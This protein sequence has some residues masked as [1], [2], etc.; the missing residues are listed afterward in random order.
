M[1]AVIH[2]SEFACVT[3]EP[4][5]IRVRRKPS[6]L[7][8]D[9]SGRIMIDALVDQFRMLVPLRERK[10]LGLLLDTRDAPMSL[11]E[12]TSEVIRPILVEV[13]INFSRRAV[14]VKTAVGKLQ[15][16]RRAREESARGRELVPVFDDESAAIAFLRGE[17][18]AVPA[19]RSSRRGF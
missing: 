1:I 3:R 5:F 8:T 6:P 17:E 18:P 9:N 12:S 10:G 14:L 2:E 7:A 4:G 19:P 13:M 11:D 16:I 15:A